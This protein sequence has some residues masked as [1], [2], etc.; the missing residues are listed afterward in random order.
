MVDDNRLAEVLYGLAG[1]A[2]LLA[3]TASLLGACASTAPYEQSSD[4]CDVQ[5]RSEVSKSQK[6][7]LGLIWTPLQPMMPILMASDMISKSNTIEN[8]RQNC[9][10]QAIDSRIA[11]EQNR[12]VA[13]QERQ[14]A[15]QDSQRGFK[16]VSF[17]AFQLD[18]QTMIGEKLSITGILRRSG[19][20]DVLY[21]NVVDAY[22]QGTAFAVPLLTENA[23][24]DFRQ[25]LLACRSE[26][27]NCQVT[28]LGRVT[29]CTVTNMLGVHRDDYCIEAIDGR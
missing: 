18:A 25:R 6:G 11:N 10:Q 26:Y 12:R 24:R 2:L 21:A 29:N 17:E 20:I 16:Q 8:K 22:N 3:S 14:I 5:A 23:T 9:H 28:I 27:S 19:Y 13:E 4:L 1:R 15:D 7:W